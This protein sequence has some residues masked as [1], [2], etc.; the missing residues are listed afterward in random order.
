MSAG[1]GSLGV[2]SSTGEWPAARASRC[3]ARRVIR[4]TQIVSGM[5]KTPAKNMRRSVAASGSMCSAGSSQPWPMPAL[6]K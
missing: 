2:A 3:C 1:G 4:S 5:T 6:L